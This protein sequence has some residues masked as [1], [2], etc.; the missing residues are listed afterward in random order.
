[1]MK[2]FRILLASIVASLTV[3]DAQAEMNYQSF[4]SSLSK[5]YGF[6]YNIDIS[7]LG[8]R[9]SPSGKNNAVQA[10]IYPEFSWTMTDSDAGTGVLNFAYSV[11]RYGGHNAANIASNSGMVTGI[12]DYTDNATE[13][14][15]L[16]YTYQFGGKWDWLTLGIGQYSLYN[17]DGTKYDSN[18]QVNFLNDS[19]AQNASASYSSGGLG[20]YVQIQPS[21]DWNI[22]LGGLDASN[23]DATSIRVNHL[24]DGHY[25]TFGYVAYSPI[26]HGVGELE[27]SLM[28]YNQPGVS[29]QP[30]TTNGWSLNLSQ[31]IGDKF[32]IFARVNG[33]SG[34]VEEISQSWVLGGVYNNPLNRNPLD[35][36]GLAY[37]YNK[38]DKDAVGEEL[39]HN[40]E[41][42]V[43]AYWA[44][45]VGDMLT[46]TPD[47]Q[48]YIN[49]AL[50]AKTDLGIVTSIR[51]T[52]FF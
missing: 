30:E 34:A 17:F 40:A 46:I 32:N 14:N 7:V 50:N 23:I 6:D 36:I 44:W 38:I 22:T 37:S 12:N 13:F 43:E 49:P 25:T 47:V 52:V 21:K 41:Q 20:G 16:Y 33:V 4:K 26:I 11:V 27:I 18:Q 1:M 8:Q 45:G 31:N 9:T 2:I 42:I 15:E 28:L 29:E 3:L 51:A 39:A 48:L 24:D 5:K 19:L 35:Q 10:Y